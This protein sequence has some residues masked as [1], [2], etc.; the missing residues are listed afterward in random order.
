MNAKGIKAKGRDAEN[1][2][3]EYLKRHGFPHA[4][5]RR[6]RG[7]RDAGDV[8][9]ITGTVIEVKNEKRINLSGWLS[10]L[11]RE[12]AQ[13]E[14]T[15]LGFVVAKRRGTANAGDWYAVMTLRQLTELLSRIRALEPHP[16]P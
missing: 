14:G 3:V 4:E 7:V 12:M 2:V 15:S 8:A 9:G 6:L 11:E 10:E 13:A 1:G 16:Y 5:R